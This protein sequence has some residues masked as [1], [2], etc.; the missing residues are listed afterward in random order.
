MKLYVNGILDAVSFLS[1]YAV[2][3]DHNFFLGNTPSL[4]KECSVPIYIDNFRLILIY[5]FY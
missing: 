3:N 4:S 5:K 2:P 1:T